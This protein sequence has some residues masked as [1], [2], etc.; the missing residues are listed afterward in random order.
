M[1]ATAAAA[2]Q[3]F[4]SS[5]GAVGLLQVMARRVDSAD[6]HWPMRTPT[7]LDR[8][9]AMLDKR[10]QDYF[11]RRE[12]AEKVAVKNASSEAARRAHQELADE[13]AARLRQT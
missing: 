9:G 2:D 7:S 13:Y 3:L 8:G 10:S 5:K 6:I 11:R 12:E 1:P 4:Q